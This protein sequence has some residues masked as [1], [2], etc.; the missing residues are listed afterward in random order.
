MNEGSP[1]WNAFVHP[2]LERLNPSLKSAQYQVGSEQIIDLSKNQVLVDGEQLATA[3][4]RLKALT[5]TT[6]SPGLCRRVLKPV[7]VQLWVL[8]LVGHAQEHIAEKYCDPAKSLL[9]TYFQLF[10]KIEDMQPVIDNL[11]SVGCTSDAAKPWLYHQVDQSAIEVVATT[12]PADSIFRLSPVEVITRAETLVRFV[13]VACSSE[14]IS[15]I[16]LSLLRKWTASLQEQRLQDSVKTTNSGSEATNAALHETTEVTILQ[17]LMEL[18]PEKLVSQFNELVEVVSEMIRS[19]NGISLDDELTSVVLS[20]LNMI[21]LA[22]SFGKG[23]VHA[24]E[25]HLFENFLAGMERSNNDDVSKTAK[26]LR[27]LLEFRDEAEPFEADGSAASARQIEDRRTY[28][29]ALNYITGDT[30]N[31]PPVVS[32]G[33]DMLSG[34]IVAQ[35]PVLDITAVTVML[36]SLL[37]DNEDYVNLRVIKIFTQI[38]NKH[39]KTTTQELLEHYLDSQELLP[40]DVRLRF[41]EALVQVI[42]GLGEMFAGEIAERT[43][44]VL[45]WIAGR[46]AFRPKTQARQ[47]RDERLARLKRDRAAGSQ[48]E[49]EEDISDNDYEEAAESDRRARAVLTQILR[50]WEGKRG[51]EDIRMRTSA[52]SLMGTALETNIAGIGPALVS[53]AIDSCV[54]VLSVEKEMESGILRRAAILVILGF[55]RALHRAKETGRSLG[56]GLTDSSREDVRGILKYIADTDNDGLVQQHARDVVESLETW[57]I[58]SLLSQTADTGVRRLAGLRMNPA[59]SIHDGSPRRKPRIEEIE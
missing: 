35:S 18:A 42:E 43:F 6:S 57:Q 16:F 34:L 33:L 3:L 32:E 19:D 47:A 11:L 28:N 37:K 10:G 12:E 27:M 15:G 51:S 30:G 2:L 26:N 25:A 49:G 1:G 39:P 38:A 7:I 21:I 4:M 48:D 40:T 44:R 50:G 56:F 23:D 14:S 24:A 36:S 54:N 46:R 22:P 58:S 29:L 55:V 45:L 52:L 31:P 9:R 59:V 5:L 41:G 13:C 17:K 8:S 53:D 20:L